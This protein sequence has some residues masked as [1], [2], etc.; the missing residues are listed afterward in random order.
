[1]T[2]SAS[3][4]STFCADSSNC[5]VAKPIFP[6]SLIVPA[7]EARDRAHPRHTGELAIEGL[8]L[9]PHR[10]VPEIALV[11]LEDH[12]RRGTGL[13][14]ELFFEHVGGAL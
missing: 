9:T 14:R 4:F 1:M 7:A 10:T 2:A 13:R 3:A 12:L 6:S 5:S 11:D 8:E